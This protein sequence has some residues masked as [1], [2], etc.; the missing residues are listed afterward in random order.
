[1]TAERIVVFAGPSLPPSRRPAA[2]GLEWRPPASAGD[3]AA[4]LSD[5][6]DKLC[7]IDGL[8]DSC[9]APWHKEL[10]LL[11]AAGTVVFGASSMGALRAAELD[12]HGMIGVGAIYAAYRAGRLTGDD[13]VALIHATERLEWAPLS[14]PLVELRATLIA[15]CRRRLITPPQAR[16]I[17]VAAADMHFADRDWPALRVR[18]TDEGLCDTATAAAI[19]QLHVPLKERDARACIAAAQVRTGSYRPPPSPP[20]TYFAQ[21]LLAA[22]RA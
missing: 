16:G 9:P 11:M 18:L 17:R 10:M 19:E 14:V 22:R 13:E 5:P 2:P 12:R 1:M 15:A 6:P 21:Q 7:L 4:L 8:F 3:I 20:L